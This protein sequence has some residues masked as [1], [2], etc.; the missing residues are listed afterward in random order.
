MI[1]MLYGV[2]A[3]QSPEHRLRLAASIGAQFVRCDVNGYDVWPEPSSFTWGWLDDFI[4]TATDLGMYVYPTISYTPPW[5]V[6]GAPRNTP[7]PEDLWRQLV[8][9]FGERY[10]GKVQ[11]I[12]IWN[13]PNIPGMFNGSVAQYINTLL[14][15]AA[16]ELRRIDST[17]QVCGPDLSTQ[18][19]WRPWLQTLLTNGRPW[20]DVLTVHAYG[21]PGR[22]VLTKLRD[23]R[24]IMRITNT[25]S[26]P[27][28]L[29]E[30]GWNTSRISEE[31][32]ANYLDQF[33]E[34]MQSEDW[35]I[36]ALYFNLTNESTPTQWGLFRADDTPKPAAEVFQ[37]YAQR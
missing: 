1:E 30:F 28:A 10:Q 36:A 7:P 12:S 3:H 13:E 20:L 9:T 26:L 29:T 19:Q 35:L 5:M 22:E 17:Y 33:F 24:E 23:V 16:E 15:P 2:N 4:R 27:L 25:L 11:Y 8:R 32:Q 14:Q 21:T 37:H 31:Q 6:G 34:A 18:G